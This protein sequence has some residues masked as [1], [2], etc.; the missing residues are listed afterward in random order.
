MFATS[1]PNVVVFM[2]DEQPLFMTGCY[3]DAIA[4][5]PTIDWLAARGTVFDSAYCASPIC[6]PCRAAMM[7]SRHVHDIEVW[8]NASPLRSDW[9]TF[10]HTFRAAGY[11]TILCGKMHFVGPDQHHGFEE[12]WASDI[13][14]ASFEWT[15]SNRGGVA[16][17]E[18]AQ[19][20][21][22][23]REAGPGE[24]E[25]MLYDE[26]V[27]RRAGD[28]LSRLLRDNRP[29]LLV[30][31]I[32][33]PHYPFKAPQ[34]YWDLFRDAPIPLPHLPAGFRDREHPAIRWARASGR[35]DELVTDDVC[36][37]ARRSIYGRMALVD[38]LF[39]RIVAKLERHSGLTS[40]Q[41]C[42][43]S[44]HGD[45]MGE[46][47]LWYKNTA[48]ESSTRVPLIFSGPGI[49]QRRVAETVSLLDLG[50][51]LAGLARIPAL[52]VPSA[53]RDLA[54]V[55]RGERAGQLGQAVIEN[56]GEGLHYGVRTIVRGAHKLNACQ[57]T[58]VELF[59]LRADPGEWENLA[60]H[61]AHAATVTTLQS[62]LDTASPEPAR[63]DELR[64]QSEERRLAILGAIP[65]EERPR[66]RDDW[67]DEYRTTFGHAPV[68]EPNLRPQQIEAAK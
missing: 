50:P 11:R 6:C 37:R 33:G 60:A 36:L 14:P 20:I 8:D 31:S 47:G 35:M 52:G 55:I 34:R 44:D 65:V 39:K 67:R 17:N 18:G 15:R 21:D 58:P 1:R 53:G 29:F 7:T 48:F 40:T 61:P 22:S 13:Y 16:V 51:T 9:P 41:L 63:Y 49:A 19:T 43:L 30:V 54:P 32:T 42:F 2:V 59:D 5:T 56:Y 23:V 10:A 25:D 45:M 3:G 68:V 64:W 12:R 66:W 46:H 62:A 28:G 26:L 27:I 24:T 57:T 38:D 4:R